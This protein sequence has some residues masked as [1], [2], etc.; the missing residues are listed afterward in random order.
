M[1][2]KSDLD[3]CFTT[4]SPITLPMLKVYSNIFNVNCVYVTINNI[5]FIPNSIN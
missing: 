3:E 1:F 4:N 5:K 2:R